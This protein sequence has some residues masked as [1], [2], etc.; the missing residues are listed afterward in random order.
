MPLEVL[1]TRQMIVIFLGV[2]ISVLLIFFLYKREKNK[3]RR[4]EMEN[5]WKNA[6]KDKEN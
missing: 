6:K 4:K 3:G 5:G 2:V 1:G